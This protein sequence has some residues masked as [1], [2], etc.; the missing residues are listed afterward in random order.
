MQTSLST[1]LAGRIRLDGRDRLPTGD[2]QQQ[3][4]VPVDHVA[5]PGAAPR[6]EVVSKP[7]TPAFAF[8]GEL[9]HS[10]RCAP[11]RWAMTVLRVSTRRQRRSAACSSS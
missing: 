5:D 9:D 3:K 10:L 8:Q 7:A 1:V 6:G 4:G 2:M 11:V